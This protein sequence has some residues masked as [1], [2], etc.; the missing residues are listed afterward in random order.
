MIVFTGKVAD[1]TNG[2]EALFGLI[3]TFQAIGAIKQHRYYVALS[4]SDGEY[5]IEIRNK[6]NGKENIHSK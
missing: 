2:R 4:I 6:Q 3:A 5:R 1:L